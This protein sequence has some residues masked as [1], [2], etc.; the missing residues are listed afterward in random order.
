LAVRALDSRS[1]SPLRIRP[2]ARLAAAYALNELGDWLGAVAL[3][4]LVFARTGS[5][6]ALTAL[7]LA[8]RLVPAFVA[9]AMTARL[10]QVPTRRALAALYLAEA[11]LFGGLA[12][13][14]GSFWL[15]AVLALALLDGTLALTARALARAAIA[16]ALTP[17]G[18]LREGNALVNVGFAIAAAAGPAAAGA[19]VA[20]LGITP[21]LALDA[22]SF[23]AIA[24]LLARTAGL[25]DGRPE[26]EPW[27]GRVRAGLGYAWRDPRLR[28]LLSGQAAALVFFTAVVPIEVVYAKESLHA[29]DRGFGLLLAA[30]GGGIVVGSLLFARTRRRPLMVIV[31]STALVG[32]AYAG[33]ASAGTL[34]VACAISAAG[35]CGNG[36]QWVAVVTAVQEATAADLQA[37]VVGLLESV[38]AAMPGLGFL[39]GG[40]VT[41]VA[42]PRAAYL[43]AGLGVL[44]VLA[45]AAVALSRSGRPDSL[46]PTSRSRERTLA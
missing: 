46:R 28:L 19:L 43:V 33:L 32:V 23:A 18:L 1:L 38:G 36:L 39:L 44:A 13:L 9:P 11:A 15:P 17:A 16:A 5:P 25:P 21:A 2:F 40:A 24:L 20:G 45:V 4:I 34:A 7:F 29:G 41:A 8:S 3:A 12:A 27:L 6:L 14:A 31:L 10:D 26:R 42:S 30:W 35:G 22:A 37:R